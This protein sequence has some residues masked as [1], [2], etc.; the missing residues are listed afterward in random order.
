MGVLGAEASVTMLYL[1]YRQHLQKYLM[2]LCVLLQIKAAH[3]KGAKKLQ[4]SSPQAL[5]ETSLVSSFFAAH[6]F[7]PLCAVIWGK[8]HGWNL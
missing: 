6:S 1:L 4:V 3:R 2:D 8:N 7:F 5:A